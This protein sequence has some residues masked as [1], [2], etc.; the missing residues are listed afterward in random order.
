MNG[1]RLR[2]LAIS[3]H[4]T[5]R[6]LDHAMGELLHAAAAEWKE[7]APGRRIEDLAGQLDVSGSDLYRVFRGDKRLTGRLLLAPPELLAAVV[8]EL[9]VYVL[10]ASGADVEASVRMGNADLVVALADLQAHDTRASIDGALTPSECRAGLELC[11][12]VR[13]E[14]EKR[15]RLYER[16]L[17]ERGV[18]EVPT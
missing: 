7:R 9:R 5:A 10:L 14:I 15:E 3:A 17:A 11:R 18:S 13:G 1:R 12:A 6:D 2:E 8:R 16:G 4:R